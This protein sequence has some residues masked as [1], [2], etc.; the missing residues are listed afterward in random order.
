MLLTSLA[1]SLPPKTE[2]SPIRNRRYG[3][4]TNERNIKAIHIPFRDV[5]TFLNATSWTSPSPSI[6]EPFRDWA[7]ARG[8]N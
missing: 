6:I 7:I 5:A 1:L 3:L 8:W 4:L 2:P